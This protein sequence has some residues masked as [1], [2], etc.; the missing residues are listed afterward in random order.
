MKL[1]NIAFDNLKRRKSKLVFLTFGMV[2]AIATVVT[3]M[4]VTSAMERDIAEQLDAFGAN[5]MVVPKTD[6]LSLSYGG[7]VVSGVSFDI[8]ELDESAVE[9]I[10]NIKNNDNL[11]V[12]APKLLGAVEVE[13]E[14]ILLVGTDFEQELELKKWWKLVGTEPEEEND[15]LI[16]AQA[17]EKLGKNVGDTIIINNREFKISAIIEETGSLDDG[18]IFAGLGVTQELLD[19]EGKLSLIEVSAFCNSCPIEEMV[20]QMSV[21]LP[22]AKVT[23]VKQLVKSRMD[24]LNSLSGFTF[25]ISSV[26]LLVG[27]L[28]VMTTMMS[29]VNERTREIGIFRAIGFRK[30]HVVKIILLEAFIISLIG[31]VVGFLIG[32]L[33]SI[34]AAPSLTGT[35]IEFSFS[36]LLA[37]IAITVSISVGGAA[38][39]YPA[40]KA[41]K[42]DPSEALRH[43]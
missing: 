4:S 39:L 14:R 24:T 27:A 15:V 35:N 25:L 2:I 7:L 38:S 31:G 36:P 30:A 16:G 20:R 43:I 18:L 33:G 40:L 28:I 29:S 21:A 42:L 6:E 32:S 26:V 10:W 41:S 13:G 11:N 19:K 1:R 34:F 17:A 8:K 12:V 9:K 37:F 23:A 3:M 22:G 5:I